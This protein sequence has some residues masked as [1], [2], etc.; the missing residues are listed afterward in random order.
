MGNAQ[1]LQPH[2]TVKGGEEV[3]TLEFEK[4]T[5]QATISQLKDFTW[6]VRMAIY[7]LFVLSGQSAAILLGR[8]Y[9]NKGGKNL[10][11]AT[12][13]QFIGFPILIPYH[14]ILSSKKIALNRNVNQPD[15]SALA[16]MYLSFG[17]L[18]AADSFLYSIGLLY[19]PVSTF[20][21]ICASQLAFNAFF[22]F[23]LNAQKFTPCIVN[24]LVIL[25]ISSTLLV[26]HP[27]SVNLTGIS[28]E[29]YTVGVICTV[30]ASA[31]YGLMFSLTQFSFEK[32]LKSQ[33]FVTVLE[34]II[35]ESLVATCA[36]LVGLFISEEWQGLKR[37]ME[38]FE[39]GRSSYLLTLI[40]TAMAWQTFNIGAIGLIFEV[41]SLFS[42]VISASGLPFVPVLAVIFFKENMDG[43]KVIATVLALWGFASYLYQHYL[44]DLESKAETKH[45]KEISMIPLLKE[46]NF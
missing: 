36:T 17:V 46:D 45:V 20:S 1:D 35:Y 43:I 38:E 30:G 27:N 29:K 6:W 39:L 44:D 15:V 19:L 4:I 42:N 31:G 34:M 14:C 32:V 22:S 13:V 3:N 24:S 7:T 41:S 10:W 5:H 28:K 9:Y 8:L 26:F 12:L 16:F 40:C 11:M 23:C 21:L 18:L 33:T 37:E 2:N 25:T